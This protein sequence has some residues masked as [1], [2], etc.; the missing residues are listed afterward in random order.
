[1]AFLFLD[2]TKDYAEGRERGTDSK[3]TNVTSHIWTLDKS[4]CRKNHER[5]TNQLIMGK[6][7]WTEENESK[8]C[9]VIQAQ[10]I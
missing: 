4:S 8:M 9:K 7:R 6:E 3:P 5:L 10:N 2:L 1:M